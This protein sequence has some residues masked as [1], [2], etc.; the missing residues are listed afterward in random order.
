MIYGRK[1]PV[2]FMRLNS[3][4]YLEYK[5]GNIEAAVA[6]QEEMLRQYGDAASYQQASIAAGS[7]DA[8]KTM[9]WL[10]RAYTSRDPGLT[11]IKVDRDFT[12]QTP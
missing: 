12:L 1:E 10:E 9:E 4:G 6:V 11:G 2:D 8:D 7:G 5:L 3:V